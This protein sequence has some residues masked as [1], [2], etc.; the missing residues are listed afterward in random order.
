V[1]K[2]SRARDD[3]VIE[4]LENDSNGPVEESETAL[5][6]VVP[7]R[8]LRKWLVFAHLKL[9]EEPGKIDTKM[10][11]V[12]DPKAF[13]GYRPLT[14]LKPPNFEQSINPKA[15]E[16]PGHYRRI[17][18]SAFQ[19]LVEL[20]G[21]NGPVICVR[22]FPYDDLFRW[23]VFPTVDDIDMVRPLYLRILL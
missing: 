8:W 20:Y 4:I 5:W 14:T 9:G 23:R 21:L 12:Q 2:S 17:S 3:E 18:L 13:N 6:I 22:G 16:S 10:L 7:S 11:L 1:G 15:K 19:K